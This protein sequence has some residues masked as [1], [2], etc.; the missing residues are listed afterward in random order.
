MGKGRW[1]KRILLGLGLV[2]LLLT[3][4]QVIMEGFEGV[5]WVTSGF[6]PLLLIGIGLM[7]SQRGGYI[8]AACR[9]CIQNDGLMVTYPAI[10]YQDGKGPRH[11]EQ[12]IRKENIR[13]IQYSSALVS[14]RII[15][16]M[17][18]TDASQRKGETVL[19]PRPG[20]VEAMTDAFTSILGIQVTQM[21]AA[22]SS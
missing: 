11:E 9:V 8:T 14:F 4:F 2:I 12:T 22:E 6:V 15:W 10:D 18:G 17:N 5:N 21:D 20:Q 19:Y 16:E 7:G 13:F 3:A 1:R